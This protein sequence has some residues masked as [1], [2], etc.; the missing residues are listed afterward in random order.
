[1]FGAKIRYDFG[2]L[3]QWLERLLHTLEDAIM[4]IEVEVVGIKKGRHIP[5]KNELT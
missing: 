1:M 3:A 5:T 4:Y 2:R